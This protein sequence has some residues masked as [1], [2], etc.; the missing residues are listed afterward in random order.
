MVLASTREAIELLRAQGYTDHG[1]ALMFQ[2]SSIP[3]PEG[4]YLRWSAVVIR[5]GVMGEEAGQ[6]QGHRP[7]PGETPVLGGCLPR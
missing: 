1:I 3:L 2:A 7:V 5:E 4:H 6:G